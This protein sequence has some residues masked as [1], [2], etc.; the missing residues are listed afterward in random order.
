MVKDVN[1]L[2]NGE[3]D[4]YMLLKNYHNGVVFL[5]SSVWLSFT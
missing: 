3:S 4:D 1:S 2:I 5:L